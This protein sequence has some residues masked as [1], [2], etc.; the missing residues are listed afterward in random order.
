MAGDD[1]E[2]FMTKSLDVTPK[3][4][5]QHLIVRVGKSEAEVT[6]N[7]RARSRW[8]TIEAKANY[9]QT[10]RSRGLSATADILFDYFDIPHISNL[11]I[12]ESRCPA[13]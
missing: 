9:R 5:E 12:V 13:Y 1:D 7:R 3:T 6:N 2:V 11:E 8:C 4:T 10:R